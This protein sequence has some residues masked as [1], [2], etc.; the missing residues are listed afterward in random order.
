M[1][2]RTQGLVAFGA[3]AAIASTHASAQAP[4]IGSNASLQ[5]SAAA[6]TS[7]PDLL[8][9]AWNRDHGPNWRLLT[10]RGTG[11]LEMLH[12]GNAAPPFE[13]NTNREQDWFDLARFW[14][15][16]TYAMHGVEDAELQNP[17]FRYLPLAQSNTTDKITVRFEQMIEGVPVEQSAINVL[18]DT[19][20]RLLSI[21][22]T[23]APSLSNPGVKPVINAGFA[24]LVAAD[25]FKRQHGFEPTFEGN[26]RLVHAWIDTGEVRTWELA[27]QTEVKYEAEG[28]A[29]LGRMYTID[30]LGRNILKSESTVHNFDVF[31]TVSSNASPG[32]SA[33]SASNP[34]TPLVMPRVRITSSAGTVE[35][36]RDGNFNIVGV[37]TPVNLTVSYFGQFTDVNNEAGADYTVTFPNV[38]PN[39]QNNLLM[40]PNPTQ[41]VTAQAN[42]QLHINTLRDFI[43]DRFPTDPTADFRATARVNINQN[44]NA[45]FS[46]NQVNFYTAGGGCNNTAFSAVVVHEMGHWLN[47]RYGTGNGNDGMGEGNAD[48]FALYVYDDPV[49]GRG[50]STNGGAVRNGNNNRQFCGDNNPSCHGGVHNNGEVWMGA[51]WKIRE[52]LDASLGNTMGDMTADL[53]FLGWLNSYNQSQIRSIIEAQWLTLDDDDGN[54]NNGSPN[55]TEIDA[56]FRQQG[57][58]GFELSTFEFGNLTQVQDTLDEGGPYVVNADVIGLLGTQITSVSVNYTVNGGALQTLPMSNAGGNT[59]SAGIPGQLS[60]STVLYYIEASN[61]MGETRTF[62][63]GA[64]NAALRFRVGSLITFLDEDFESGTNAWS[65]VAPGD[66][67]TTGRWVLGNPNGTAAQPEDDTSPFGENCWFTGQGTPGGG[68]GANDVDG[69]RTTLRTPT[70]DGSAATAMTLTY[71]RWYSNDEGGSPNGDVFDVDVSNDGGVTWTRVEQVGPAGNSTSGGWETVSHDLLS[72]TT[73]SQLMQLRFVASDLGQG[74]IVEAAIDD[75]SLIQFTSSQSPPANFCTSNV[76]STGFASEISAGGSQSISQNNFVLTAGGVPAGQFGIFFFGPGQIDVP[77]TNSQGRLCIGGQIRRTT[78]VQADPFFGLASL[79]V[80]LT[81]PPQTAIT[82]GSTW[83]FQ[84]WFRDVV[85][86][87]ATSNTSNGVSVE[88]GS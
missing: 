33:D 40:N 21:H 25:A 44:C 66:N 5:T 4:S 45:T 28:E 34:P 82:P 48:V 12:G 32:T 41:L 13:P 84:F 55:Y 56:G 36:D 7:S 52:Q 14:I 71:S 37:N 88:F 67:A 9:A 69:G 31:G 54:I 50:F 60:P 87:Q 23:A 6:A 72:V 51:A 81:A 77:L 68:L 22:T 47:S 62:P 20:G 11:M 58:P 30:A 42:A 75:L 3:L 80:D 15:G 8:L 1:V 17:Q 76:N 63:E 27:W 43:R 83:N 61:N 10:T 79:S 16:E 49:M 85:A 19:S 18:F 2:L 24:N 53:L 86:G 39:Q 78:P 59:F 26:E 65:G 35:T 74:S 46:G 73:P 64:L 70:F 29:T 57:F 38:Q